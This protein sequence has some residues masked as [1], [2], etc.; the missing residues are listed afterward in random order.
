MGSTPTR[1]TNKQKNYNIEDL[2]MSKLH[3]VIFDLETT[4]TNAIFPHEEEYFPKTEM[5]TIEIGAVYYNDNL[6]YVHGFNSIVKPI[7]HPILTDFC[8][9]LTKI[10]QADVDKADNFPAV[11]TR[12]IKWI[13]TNRDGTPY[14]LYAW[15]NFDK[16]QL[17]RDFV[18]HNIEFNWPE[19]INI[20]QMF[21]DNVSNKNMNLI[22][23]CRKVGLVF[24]G[25]LHNGFDDAYN[26]ARIFKVMKEQENATI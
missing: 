7:R 2:R 17:E 5:E 24:V 20:R 19:Y 26:T 1:S 13:D 10:T 15:G 18:Y 14:N 25:I 9:D 16:K 4:C 22:D 6:S 21:K 8:T 12:F 3:H 11:F 23:A